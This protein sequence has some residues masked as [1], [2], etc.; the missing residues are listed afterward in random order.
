MDFQAQNSNKNKLQGPDYI[1]QVLF[2]DGV[3]IAPKFV[4]TSDYDQYKKFDNIQGLFFDGQPY[5]GKPTQV[6]CWYG[7][8]KTLAEGKKAP[9]VVLVHGGGGTAFP[10]WVKKW[11][12]KGYIAISIALEGQ[13][14]GEKI[15]NEKGTREYQNLPNSG[16]ARFGFFN[17][18][19]KDNL[20]DQWFYH[21]VSDVILAHSLLRSFPEVDASKIG[22]T[23]ISWG[24]ILTN[25]VTG[26]DNRFIFS[27]PVYGC[28][29]LYET[30]LYKRLLSVLNS[31]AQDFYMTHWE[32]SLYVPLQK[33]PT[34]FVNG[35]ND[36]HFTMNSFTKTYEA[37]N[38]EKYLYVEHEMKHGH[39]P[40]WTPKEIYNFADY[41]TKGASKPIKLSIKNRSDK[42]NRLTYTYE[43]DAIES[44]LYYTTD[45]KN[46]DH[47]SYKW[48]K[49]PAIVSPSDKIIKVE[50]PK[51]AEYFF[52]NVTTP[53]GFVYSSSM[54]KIECLNKK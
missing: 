34:L 1:K 19:N 36:K 7:V 39:G 45:A 32:P 38:N 46:W 9:A 24:G 44:E 25:V 49:A 4:K 29:F 42:K 6:F 3:L 18:V 27:I 28:G 26:I 48:I 15:D 43:G 53:G 31:N 13:I 21:A 47:E 16:P 12:D 52:I 5:K 22:I 20:Q 8:P 14:P 11:N 35:T 33:L 41:I 51:K 30:P 50:L 37:S 2:N 17:D 23:G 54:E 40:G 10:Q